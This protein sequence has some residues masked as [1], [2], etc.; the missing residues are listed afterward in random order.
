M[1][2]DTEPSPIFTRDGGRVY[3][4]VDYEGPKKEL[5]WQCTWCFRRVPWNRKTCPNCAKHGLV[6]HRVIEEEVPEQQPCAHCG[7]KCGSQLEFIHHNGAKPWKYCS[8]CDPDLVECPECDGPMR[9]RQEN[10]RLVLRCKD[11]LMCR[12]KQPWDPPTRARRNK[13]VSRRK[14][15]RPRKARVRR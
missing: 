10:G 12:G 3:R 6:T 15:A 8:G 5:E 9:V 4:L 14:A 7:D 13:K 11:Y 2:I 1:S